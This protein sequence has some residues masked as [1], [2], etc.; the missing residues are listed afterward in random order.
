MIFLLRMAFFILSM[1]L[2]F[3]LFG[4]ILDHATHPSEF[5]P[6][7]G[8]MTILFLFISA[9]ISTQRFQDE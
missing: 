9:F 6:N 5:D 4:C 1:T 7:K 2:A 3:I 8:A